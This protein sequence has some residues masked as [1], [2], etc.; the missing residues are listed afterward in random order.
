LNR[1]KFLNVC[2]YVLFVFW[3][4][5]TILQFQNGQHAAPLW[6]CNISVAFLAVACFQRS[7]SMLYFFL[8][9][10]LFFQTPWIID[11]DRDAWI[12]EHP[13]FKKPEIGHKV[14]DLLEEEGLPFTAKTLDIAY[15]Y[16]TKDSQV[17]K[18]KDETAKETAKREEAATLEREEASA[19]GGGSPQSKGKVPHENPFDDLVG[20]AVNPNIVRN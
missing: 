8:A 13:E 1:E 12:G 3:I 19:V 4:V 7:L 16:V 6:F 17:K 9:S 2:G 10:G 15:N 14:L 5:F 20:D 18:A 11:W